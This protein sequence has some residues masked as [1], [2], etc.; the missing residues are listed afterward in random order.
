MTKSEWRA[1]PS[2]CDIE[3]SAAHTFVIL[4]SDFIRISGF[5]FL[6]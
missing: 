2:R 4:I 6:V 3:G 5:G 1:A